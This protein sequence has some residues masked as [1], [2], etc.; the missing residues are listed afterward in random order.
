MRA[1]LSFLVLMGAFALV[2][3]AADDKKAAKK[4]SPADAGLERFKQLAG[5]WVGKAGEGKDAHPVHVSYKVTSGGSTVLE[6]ITPSAEHEM[7]T[8]IHKDGDD[9]VLTHYCSLGN[10][11]HMKAERSGDD[12]KIAFKFAGGANIKP[13]KDMHMHEAT[14]TFV[15]KNTLKAEWTLYKDGKAATTVAFDLKRKK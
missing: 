5:D 4:E 9:L 2:A 8:A 14:F 11:P 3:N 15:D 12:K 13:D 6:T 7:V 1:A 10:Q